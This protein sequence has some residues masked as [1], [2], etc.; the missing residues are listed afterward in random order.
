M[1]NTIR[2]KTIVKPGGLVEIRS[3]ELPE[4]VTVEV[5]IV[6]E[7]DNT[8]SVCQ[9]LVDF[10]GSAKGCFLSPREADEFIRGERDAWD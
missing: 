5:T 3:G 9:S 2:E 10:I 7:R 4:G 1:I 8:E 6:V